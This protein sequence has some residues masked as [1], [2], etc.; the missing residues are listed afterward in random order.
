MLKVLG[1]FE[2]LFEGKLDILCDK[3]TDSSHDFLSQHENCDNFSVE[4][5]ILY[6]SLKAKNDSN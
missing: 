6:N 5:L 2:F 1:D 4:F 3:D